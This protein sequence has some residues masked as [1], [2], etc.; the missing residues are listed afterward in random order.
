MSMYRHTDKHYAN[1]IHEPSMKILENYIKGNNEFIWYKFCKQKNF[2]KEFVWSIKYYF[3]MYYFCFSQVLQMNP[4][5]HITPFCVTIFLFEQFQF[6]YFVIWLNKS[7]YVI[8]LN[9]YIISFHYWYQSKIFINF[10]SS[11]F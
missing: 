9:P 2:V 7:Y 4:I 10:Y 6:T 3:L 11:I 1:Y 5:Y 8:L